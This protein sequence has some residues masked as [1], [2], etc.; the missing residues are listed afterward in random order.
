MNRLF[1]KKGCSQLLRM[2][3][4]CAVLLCGAAGGAWGETYYWYS[5]NT[6]GSWSESNK[7][8]TES[9]T[10][11]V[12]GGT[13]PKASDDVAVFNSPATITLAADVTIGQFTVNGTTG[14]AGVLTF[15]GGKTLTVSGSSDNVINGNG[16]IT[17]MK[18]A[19]NTSFTGQFLLHRGIN[20]PVDSGY[21][22]A[23]AD[24]FRYNGGA[25]PS[26]SS[27]TI[28][29]TLNCSYFSSY[30]GTTGDAV[31]T[32]DVAGTVSSSGTIYFNS[33]INISAEG[34]I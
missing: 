5:G 32:L 8:S 30:N 28:N 15:T 27:I 23:T 34:K 17:G 13:Y 25:S 24:N 11:T 3:L 29:G 10:S 7:W 22:M 4:A 18:F 6:S 1:C 16:H 21:T 26:A 33:P 9:C 14:T 2:V 12:N 31:M 19:V 20:I